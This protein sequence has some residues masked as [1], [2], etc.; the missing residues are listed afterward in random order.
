ML[1]LSKIVDFCQDSLGSSEGLGCSP[2]IIKTGR[3]LVDEMDAI[4]EKVWFARTL[5]NS[6][7]ASITV[8]VLVCVPKITVMLSQE[9]SQFKDQVL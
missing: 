8:Y 1:N 2:D 4:Q 9:W 3:L 5:S 6:T 7:D